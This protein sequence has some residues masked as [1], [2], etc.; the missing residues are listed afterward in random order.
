MKNF[1]QKGDVIEVV[2]PSGGLTSGQACLFGVLPGVAQVAIAAGAKGTIATRG[3]FNLPVVGANNAG[4]V[5]VAFGDRIYNEAGVL[6]KDNVAGVAF[7]IA[8]GAVV[9][10]ATTTIPVKI[11]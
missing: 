1:V 5:A 8:L 7:G 11:G 2:G 6:N 10:G 9:S 4:N 3:V